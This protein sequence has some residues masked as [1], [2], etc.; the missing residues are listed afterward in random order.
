MR[1]SWTIRMQPVS[2]HSAQRKGFTLIELLVVIAVVAV[3]AALLLPTLTKSRDQALSLSC[4]NNLRQLQTCWLNYTHDNN[5]S[6]PPNNYVASIGPTPG[7]TN[8][9]S[10]LTENTSWCRG[11]AQL[12]SSSTNI[13]QGLL[14]PYNNSVA[15]Y[16]CPAD[17]STVTG[18]PGLLRTRSYTMNLEINC[19]SVQNSFRKMAQIRNP[20]PTG[21]FVYIDTHE[22]D[23]WDPT[24]GIFG[25]KSWWPNYWLDLPADRHRVGANLSFAD[26]HVEHWQWKTPKTFTAIF[27][28]TTSAADL[29]DLRRLQQ[30]ISPDFVPSN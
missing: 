13:Q 27:Q 12:D 6:L 1:T 29:A 8:Y 24:F 7:D 2:G 19:D 14:F 25:R 20:N 15:I 18:Q 5:D 23:I 16:R 17:R 26:G 4:I 11:I 21:L 9:P 22:Q 30:C 3:L 10:L 28:S